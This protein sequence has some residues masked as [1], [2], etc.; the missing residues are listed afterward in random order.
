MSTTALTLISPFPNSFIYKFRIGHFSLWEE[1]VE[2]AWWEFRAF[3]ELQS[4][5][6]FEKTE[7][8]ILVSDKQRKGSAC[9]SYASTMLS[10][11]LEE[12]EMVFPKTPLPKN[13]QKLPEE[14]RHHKLDVPNRT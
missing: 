6:A 9:S 7:I 12:G 14:F 1:Q 5:K 11:R 13:P 2:K 10:L 8:H 4:L 3:P